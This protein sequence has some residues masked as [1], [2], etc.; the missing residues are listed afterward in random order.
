MPTQ[1]DTDHGCNGGRGVLKASVICSETPIHA[2]ELVTLGKMNKG[3]S[4]EQSCLKQFWPKCCSQHGNKV[5]DYSLIFNLLHQSSKKSRV[6][7]Y[8]F[9]DPCNL[10]RYI[11]PSLK[12]NVLLFFPFTF[13]I[14]MLLVENS[15]KVRKRKI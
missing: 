14:K 7:L 5:F 12:G 10:D 2:T 13:S 8:V 4:A 9:Q 1:I 6:L 3:V 11:A 15:F